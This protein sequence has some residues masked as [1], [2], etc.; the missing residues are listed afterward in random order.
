M[1]TNISI[2]VLFGIFFFSAA[3]PNVAFARKDSDERIQSLEQQLEA[4][5]RAVY[6]GN[7]SGGAVSGGGAAAQYEVRVSQ[8]EQDLSAIQ[9]KLEEMN[10]AITV[11]QEDARRQSDDI[12]LRLQDLE[13]GS[14]AGGAGATA[15]SSSQSTTPPVTGDPVSIGNTEHMGVSNDSPSTTAAPE[16]QVIGGAPQKQ[17]LGDAQSLT[18]NEPT[19]LYE[20]AFRM[21]KEQQHDQAEASFKSFIE[22]YPSDS[23][24]PNAYYWLGESYYVRG[25]YDKAAK[26]FATGFQ[27][28]PDSSKKLDG[29]LKLAMSLRSLGQEKQSCVALMQLRKVAAGKPSQITTRA[30]QLIETMKCQ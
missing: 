11:L 15:S 18:N 27:K 13:A 23:L 1:K 17:I 24:T 5:N 20:S 8:L 7:A 28:F 2:F 19:Q 26:T 25:L 29:L 6:A 4:L 22:K 14:S 30:D 9:G 16:G 10:H 12:N 3:I 21:L